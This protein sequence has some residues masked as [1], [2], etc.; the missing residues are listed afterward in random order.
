MH[1]LTDYRCTSQWCAA[2]ILPVVNYL[3]L[4]P[5]E[6]L[7]TVFLKKTIQQ[8]YCQTE[9]MF[10]S[11]GTLASHLRGKTAH[12]VLVGNEWV[13]TACRLLNYNIEL[14]EF[15]LW[16]RICVAPHSLKRHRTSGPARTTPPVL[17]SAAMWFISS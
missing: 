7:H 2:H 6:L 1:Y 15:V 14:V 11:N 3:P 5:F 10:A 8:W 17:M 16:P 9:W 13:G 4:C 12:H